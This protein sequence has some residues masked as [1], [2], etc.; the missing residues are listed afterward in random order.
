MNLKL[1]SLGAAVLAAYPLL[2]R[3]KTDLIVT[4]NG[5]HITCEI[6]ELR[7]NTLFIKVDY[8][9]GTLHLSGFGS[10]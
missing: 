4:K 3:E 6:K 1:I 2:A 9:L 8:I 5:D 7:S 10:N